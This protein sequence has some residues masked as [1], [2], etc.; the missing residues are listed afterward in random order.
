MRSVTS[1]EVPMF[2]PLVASCVM[3]FTLGFSDT[4][5]ATDTAGATDAARA[6]AAAH[7]PLA[8]DVAA[9]ARTP[10][11]ADIVAAADRVRN[12]QSPFRFTLVLVE[13]QSGTAH[14]SITLA[15]HS[16]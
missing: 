10:L 3:A 5:R 1:E 9:P 15:V 6:A 16:K 2:R 13:Y 14:D 7:T 4:A 11:A 12:P 8:A